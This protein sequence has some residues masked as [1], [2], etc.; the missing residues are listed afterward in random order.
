[1]LLHQVAHKW[2]D[3]VVSLAR[4]AADALSP[5]AIAAFGVNDPRFYVKVSWGRIQ[6]HGYCSDDARSAAG[7]CS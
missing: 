7:R 1:L 5:P 4:E 6:Q 2:E 3:A